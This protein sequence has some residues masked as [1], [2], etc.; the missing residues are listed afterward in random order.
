MKKIFAILAVLA[1]SIFFV[2]ATHAVNI[3]LTFPSNGTGNNPCSDPTSNGCSP[4]AVINYFY[5]FILLVGG[6]AAFGAIVYGAIKYMASAGNPSG[7][8]EAKEWIYSALL[9]VALLAGAYLILTVVN[10]ALTQLNLPSNLPKVDPNLTSG[11]GGTVCGTQTCA[12][13]QTCKTVNGSQ[14]CVTNP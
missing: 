1:L 11:T 2:P 5:Q 9:G 7:A 4:G 12:Q 8:H 13:N 10:P 14:I 6:I 3:S